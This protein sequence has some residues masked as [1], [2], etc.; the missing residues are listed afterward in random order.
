MTPFREEEKE[1][2]YS[3]RCAICH[4]YQESRQWPGQGKCMV[5]PPTVLSLHIWARKP[6]GTQKLEYAA[7]RPTVMDDDYCL[8]F[9][10]R[11]DP[12]I[13]TKYVRKY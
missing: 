4:F 8:L 1:N 12:P 9:M 10:K 7:D 5:M 6:G 3:A 11:P 13:E 2:L